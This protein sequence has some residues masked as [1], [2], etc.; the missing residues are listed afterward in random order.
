MSSF[1]WHYLLQAGGQHCEQG[2]DLEE[3]VA[4][5]PNWGVQGGAHV[6]LQGHPNRVHLG[7]V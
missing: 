4:I 5:Q 7:Q 3:L 6:I 2:S 1:V